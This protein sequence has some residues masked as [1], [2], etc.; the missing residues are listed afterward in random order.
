MEKIINKDWSNKS[1]L[2]AEDEESNSQLL[3]EILLPTRARLVR[4]KNGKEA[5]N[6]YESSGNFDLILLDIKM[7]IMDG[8]ETA[9]YIR[10]I[11]KKIP[12]VAQTVFGMNDYLRKGKEAGFTEF[13]VKPIL[14]Q[15]LV[16]SLAVYLDDD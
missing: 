11:D 15:K 8:M 2:I 1:I 6:A 7:P 4:V 5:I 12:I 13:I 9:A 16:E 3:Y 10:G 14:P